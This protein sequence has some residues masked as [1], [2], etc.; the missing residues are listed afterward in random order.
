[1]SEPDILMELAKEMCKGRDLQYSHPQRMLEGG[2]VKDIIDKIN[3]WYPTR[4]E[5]INIELL[6]DCVEVIINDDRDRGVESEQFEVLD[7]DKIGTFAFGVF[8]RILEEERQL[9]QD[10][11]NDTTNALKAMEV[12]K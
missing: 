1:M 9:A 11:V 8:K 12:K 4:E 10:A 5:S 3:I 2:A 7:P 6:D